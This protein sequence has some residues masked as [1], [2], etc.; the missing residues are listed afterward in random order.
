MAEA[1]L[2]SHTKLLTYSALF[3]INRAVRFIVVALR[4]LEQVPIYQ[5]KSLRTYSALSR[6]LQALINSHLLEALH[7]QEMTDA[8]RFGKARIEW[9]HYL[10]PERPAFRQR[11]R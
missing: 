1:N 3:Q 2:N 11:K 4:D 10:N 9:E 7:S 5:R 6:E 8:F